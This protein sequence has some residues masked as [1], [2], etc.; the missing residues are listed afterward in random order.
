MTAVI[1]DWQEALYITGGVL[2]TL[3]VIAAVVWWREI[4]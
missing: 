3:L 2:G 1:V 4:R